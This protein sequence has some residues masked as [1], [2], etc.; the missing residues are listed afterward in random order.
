MASTQKQVASLAGVS[1]SVVS[2]VFGGGVVS[3]AAKERV[4]SIAKSVGYQPDALARSLVTGQ[5]DIVGIVMADIM[6]PFYPYVLEKFISALQKKGQQVLLFNA[7]RDQ[8]VDEE[9]SLVLQYRV[10]GIIITSASLSSRMAAACRAN[11]T[12]VVLF[13]RY[14]PNNPTWAVSCDNVRAAREI[15]DLLLDNKHTKIGYIGGNPNTSTNRDRKRGFVE[16]LAERGKKP[17]LVEDRSYSYEWGYEAAS[18][19]LRSSSVNA[20]FCANDIIALGVMDAIRNELKVRVPDD[21]SV[22]GFDDIPQASWPLYSLTTVRQPVD[23]MIDLSINLLDR[24]FDRKTRESRINLIK[25]EL[26]ERSSVRLSA[27]KK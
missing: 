7:P 3:D 25:G 6:N 20:L 14:I 13:N 24:D 19:L 16:R 12:P 1:Q 8:D 5:T 18:R 23:E 15:A 11:H 26:V 2:R 17:V 4:L 9:L 10:K 27:A 22:V 21:I